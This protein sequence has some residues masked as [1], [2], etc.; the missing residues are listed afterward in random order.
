MDKDDS[1]IHLV[2]RSE[3]QVREAQ[4][5][6]QN[7]NNTNQTQNQNNQNVNPFQSIINIVNS[8]QIRNLTN[9]IVN[10][11]FSN[12]NSNNNNNNKKDIEIMFILLI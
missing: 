10:Q 7:N 8:D 4:A 2:F 9:N 6:S 5:N 11:I 3:E 12:Q 1:I